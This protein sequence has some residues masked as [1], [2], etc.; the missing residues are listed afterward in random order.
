MSK[1][2]ICL[3]RH[4]QTDWN[5]ASLIQGRY[6][7]PLNDTGREQ[8]HI[9]SSKLRKTNIKWDVF[10]SSPLSRAVETCEIIC[11]DLSYENIKI[12]KR[13]N[14]I[15]RE[16]GEADGI[17]ICDEVYVKILSDNYK[18][19][20]TSKEIN[21]RAINEILDIA[22]TYPNKNVLV[23][24]HS[25]FIKGAFTVLDKNITFK[26]TLYNGALNFIIVEDNNIV[27]FHFNK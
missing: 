17:P 15:E 1:T 3:V 20:E 14:L 11:K 4:G 12:I 10:L 26:S 19:I 23:T 25:H 13:E 8:I 22:K 16:F 21:D 6:D 5:K 24:T 27:E 7:I 18:G 9:T 2:I